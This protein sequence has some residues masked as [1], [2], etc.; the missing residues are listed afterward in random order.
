M[1]DIIRVLQK[2][3]TGRMSHIQMGDK[4]L[5]F[6]HMRIN[7]GV[8]QQKVASGEVCIYEDARETEQKYYFYCCPSA[9]SPR[10]NLLLRS[11]ICVGV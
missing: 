3:D 9:K 11:H 4:L 2:Y 1:L 5:A 7:L 6:V 10:K 8:P